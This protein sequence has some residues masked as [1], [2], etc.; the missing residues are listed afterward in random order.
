VEFRVSWA[1][2][3]LIIRGNAYK[4]RRSLGSDEINAPSRPELNLYESSGAVELNSHP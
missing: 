3:S 2:F 4:L 1:V